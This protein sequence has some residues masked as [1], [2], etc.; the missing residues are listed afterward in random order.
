MSAVAKFAI[1]VDSTDLAVRPYSLKYLHCCRRRSFQSYAYRKGPD[2][3]TAPD[4]LVTNLTEEF[5]DKT[6]ATKEIGQIDDAHFKVI[7]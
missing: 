5:T 3:I 6:V 4:D 1:Q 2:L 7:G